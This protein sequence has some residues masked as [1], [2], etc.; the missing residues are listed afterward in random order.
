MKRYF[1]IIGV[2]QTLELDIEYG[3]PASKASAEKLGKALKSNLREIDKKEY[4][5]LSNQFTK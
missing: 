1:E 3:S 4:N 2:R 5:V